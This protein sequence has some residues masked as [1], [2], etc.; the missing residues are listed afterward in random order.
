VT[1]DTKFPEIEI[2][3]QFVDSWKC[4]HDKPVLKY[5]KKYIDDWFKS[6]MVDIPQIEKIKTDEGWTW[7]YPSH[8]QWLEWYQ[9]WFG[10]FREEQKDE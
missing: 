1:E 6:C 2:L 8:N 9:K 10:Q 3:S 4:S 5:D 7:N